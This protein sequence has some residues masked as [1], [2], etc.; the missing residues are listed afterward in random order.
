MKIIFLVSLLF[1]SLLF[2][3]HLVWSGE[4]YQL[5]SGARG[6][7]MGG[8]SIAVVDDETALLINPAAL[9]KLRNSY[10]TIFD[11]EIES[12]DNNSA[13]YANSPYSSQYDLDSIKTSLDASRERYYHSKMQIFP[14][15]VLKNFGIGAY[16]KYLLGAQTNAAGT[17]VA[18]NYFNDMAAIMGFSIRIWDGRIKFGFNA[19]V[20]NRVQASGTY[21]PATD[22]KYSTIA[23]GGSANSIDAGLILTAPWEWLP[24]LSAVVHDVGNT[25]FT[26]TDYVLHLTNRPD[27]IKQDADVAIAL[28]PIHSSSSR[29]EFTVQSDGVLTSS[30]EPDKQKLLHIGYELN[31]N[32]IGFFRLGMNGRYYTGGIEM[33]SERFQFMWTYYGEE[34]GTV[35]APVQD[36]RNVFKFAYRF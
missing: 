24:T 1:C 22:L 5:Y 13:I 26:G 12:S 33:A 17:E 27:E 23:K 32:D 9:G 21:D 4:R 3:S 34:V 19:K 7:A 10:G 36:R 16:G 35:D 8:A 6:L 14:S 2:Y 28:F 18:A 25:K 30:T 29:S 20:L 31:I 11:P 15:F